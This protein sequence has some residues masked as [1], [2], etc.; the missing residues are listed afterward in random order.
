MDVKVGSAPN[1][2][3]VWFADD[4][5]QMHWSRFLDEIA[6][7]GFEYTELGPYGYLPTDF[8][9]LKNELDKRQLKVSGTFVM[10]S[11]ADPAA[12]PNL[13]RQLLGA[14]ELLQKLDAHFIILIDGLYT[15]EK[16]G[17]PVGPTTWNDDEWK[18]AMDTSHR[19]GEIA[20]DRFDLEVAFHPHAQSH[21]EYEDQIE[22]YLEDTDPELIKICLDTGHFAYRG[23]NP[24]ELIRR[25]HK[26][27]DYLHLKS[28]DSEVREK[29]DREDV[30][31]SNAVAMSMFCEPQE[32]AVDFIE[33]RDVLKE[34]DWEGFAIAE[35][36]MYPCPP[37]K[38]FPI[39][40]RT[41]DYFREIGI[42]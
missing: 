30:P 10:D 5:K 20:R 1:S 3:G 41:R 11:L 16:T 32:G 15:D 27:I 7:A 29:V 9:T 8:D 40:K 36:D 13:E 37:D 25:H 26:R 14:G 34:Y 31:F 23:G 22:R 18:R 28:I 39:A 17:Q 19:V 4:E 24:I 35:Q 33:L 12:W 21:V 6:A 38:P 42:G 2:W